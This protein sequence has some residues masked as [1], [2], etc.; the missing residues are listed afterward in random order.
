MVYNYLVGF[1]D[2][3]ISNIDASYNCEIYHFQMGYRP[4]GVVSIWIPG[5]KSIARTSLR[6]KYHL[7]DMVHRLLDL[8]ALRKWNKRRSLLSCRA[9]H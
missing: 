5:I 4:D 1:R 6:H 8:F 3:G 2:R 9:G 7:V